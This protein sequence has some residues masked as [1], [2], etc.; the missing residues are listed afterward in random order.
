MIDDLHIENFLTFEKLNINGLKRVNLIAGKNNTGKTALLE[1]IRILTSSG[2]NTV[3]N[4]I[5]FERGHF[6]SGWEESYDA[7]FNRNFFGKLREFNAFTINDLGF[8][9]EFI[10]GGHI[11]YYLYGQHNSNFRLNI[12]SNVVHDNPKDNAVYIPYQMDYQM[13][14]NLRDEII[15]SPKENQV[16]EIIRATILPDLERFDIGRDKIRVKLKGIKDA[17]PLKSLGDGARRIFLIAMSLASADGKYLLIDEL[18]MG[19]HYTV[20]RKLWEMIFKYSIA[21]NIQVFVT[22]HSQDAI[23]AFNYVVAK[24]NYDNAAKFLR[25]QI[26]RKEEL[27][28]I[29]FD[30]EDLEDAMNLNIEIR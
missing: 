23:E 26:N 3:I 27:E 6:Q 17:L 2:H 21:W 18:E 16:I 30:Q 4:N 10:K 12:N 22:T 9:K 20:L 13:F 15:L 1:A 11:Q 28:T 24:N 19:L 7:L 14:A 5:L 25:L 29:A 8:S